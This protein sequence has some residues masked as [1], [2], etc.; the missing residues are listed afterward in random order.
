MAKKKHQHIDGIL[1]QWDYDHEAINA[2]LVRGADGREVIQMRV[3]MG[4]LQMEVAGRPDGTRPLGYRTYYHY[5]VSQE[6]DDGDFELTAEQCGEADREFLQYYHRRVC[7]LTLREFQQAVG[8]ADHTLA[9]MDLCA[10][11]SPDEEWTMSHEQYR[12]FVLFHRTQ[13]AAL[14]ELEAGS[15]EAAIHQINE[16]LERLHRLFVEHEVEEYFEEDELVV[17]LTELR[18]SLRD[19]YH[20]GR[21]LQE[22]LQDAVASEQYELAAEL[23]DELARRNGGSRR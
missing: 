9:M 1:R 14:V 10:R 6:Q 11:H 7:W 22:R 18:E 3:D 5:L 19:H 16:G 12:P 4:V 8:D 13:A 20:V 15:P 2:R 21:T 23:R 17:R